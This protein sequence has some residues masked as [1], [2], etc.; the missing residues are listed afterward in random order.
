MVTALDMINGDLT[1]IMP[2][3]RVTSSE[4]SHAVVEMFGSV[5]SADYGEMATAIWSL[6]KVTEALTLTRE[7]VKEVF[8]FSII[9]Y[10]F[11]CRVIIDKDPQ[12]YEF[13][14]VQLYD[15]TQKQLE[16]SHR[17]LCSKGAKFDYAVNSDQKP[18]TFSVGFSVA[19]PR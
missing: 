7:E 16:I 5:E 17:I 10:L 19:I 9:G 3:Y 15:R 6:R 18:Q 2:G 11:G 1:F 8:G 14:A 13:A 12:R 4:L